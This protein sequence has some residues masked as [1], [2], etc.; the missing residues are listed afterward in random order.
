MSSCLPSRF[1]RG[2]RAACVLRSGLTLALAG[3]MS[4]AGP[5]VCGA[6]APGAAPPSSAA[7]EAPAARKP[8]PPHWGPPPPIQTM[9]FRPLP[10]GYGQGSSTLARWI[11]ANLDKDTAAGRGGAGDEAGV[12]PGP[13][14][15]D[16]SG[17]VTVSGE[18]KQ[19]HKVT[20]T[21]DGPF[22]HERDT[23]PN[24]FTDL[25][26]TVVF[27]HESGASRIEVPGYFAADGAAG[28]TGAESGTKWRAHVAPDRPGR[29]RYAVSFV[30]GPGV[31]LDAGASGA[32]IQ[33]DRTTGEFE[34][35]PTDKAGRD[36]RA[37]GW[38]RYVGKHHLQFAGSGRYF[39]KVGADAPENLLAYADFDGTRANKST[40]ARPGENAPAGRLKT[41]EP[42][43]RDWREGD[44][45]WRG[46]KGR[47]LIGALNYLAS[48]GANGF[49]FLP[50][51]AGGDGD[52]VWP[53]VE[54]EAKRHYDCS[55]LDQ[56]GVVFDHATSR[57]LFLHFKLQENEIDDNRRGHESRAG[58]V[59]E[60]LDG[61]ALGPERRLYCREL[62]AR[63]A[64]NLALNWNLG[65]ENT[66][67]SEEIRDM[68]RY[69]TD[70]D[71]YDHPVVIHTFPDQQDKV[72]TPLLGAQSV[73]AGASLQNSW[74]AA[75]QRTLKWVAESA[76]AGRPWVVCND[77]QNP[78]EMG[79]PPDPG[80]AGHSG[81]ALQG[82][83]PYTLDDIRKS[84]LWGTL[85]A[86]GA[87]VEYY[88]GY[89]LPQNDLQCEDWRSRERSWGYGRLAL[90]FF[91]D[92][93]IPFWQMQ[94]T[95]TLVGNPRNDNSRYGLALPGS[96]Y[97]VYLP[98][99][100]EAALDLSGIEG[101]FGVRWFDP[102][103]GGELQ[104]G[105]V[106]EVD[107]G[108]VRGLGAPP[109]EAAEDW[110]VLVRRLP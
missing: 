36:F 91:H 106:R 37:H 110:V 7:A 92:H 87:G 14:G 69:I 2:R 103:R 94:N 48:Q 84:C 105:G 38:L 4:G 93:D 32:P 90:G 15:A 61:G 73:L 49:S 89:K 21:L 39:L 53:F 83:K 27:T 35:A 10:G 57:G 3:L 19:W 96:V 86:G 64:H 18:L 30:S 60:S 22:A 95:D 12:A 67:S 46:G 45:S 34:V 59:P 101:R 5:S 100:G 108:G 40:T 98:S 76:K 77:E 44:P 71:P 107:G 79:V 97:V 62:V 65:E 56:W 72:Y 1:H 33:G 109:A 63:F 104:G 25:R 88:F 54:R 51:N 68:A 66:Q 81:E 47:G 70:L 55:K 24:P 16:G 42:H 80:Y 43:V 52:D 74:S 13:R 17:A 50:Y 82:G 78:A 75:H 102:R 99:G 26:L 8:F 11:Q 41:W 85:M 20:L 31:A 58:L 23:A 6:E 29:W 9:D 28:E